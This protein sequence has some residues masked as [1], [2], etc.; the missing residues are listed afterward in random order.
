MDFLM[1]V[2]FLMLY[3]LLGIGRAPFAPLARVELFFQ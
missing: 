2:L 3:V 1:V